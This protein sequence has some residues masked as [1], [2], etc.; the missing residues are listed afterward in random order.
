MEIVDQ[1]QLALISMIQRL[2]SEIDT[3]TKE[4]GLLKTCNKNHH[5]RL[6][7]VAVVNTVRTI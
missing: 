2:R 6:G 3:L 4:L 1:R 7:L 5:S